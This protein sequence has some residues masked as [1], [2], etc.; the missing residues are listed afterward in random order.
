MSW[1]LICIFFVIYLLP[2][3]IAFGKNKSKKITIAI[4]N[5]LLGWTV[6]FWL[7]ALFMCTDTNDMTDDSSYLEVE[8]SDENKHQSDGKGGIWINRYVGNV[9]NWYK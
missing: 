8:D 4:T 5:V 6:I 1:W 7:I 9:I 3:A 2:T